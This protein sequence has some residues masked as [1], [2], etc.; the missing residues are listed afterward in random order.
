MT[1]HINLRLDPETHSRI[2]AVAER[3]HRSLNG[4]IEQA[5][6][7]HLQRAD[8]CGKFVHHKDGDPRNLELDS[9]E[10]RDAPRE[11]GR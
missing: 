4:E 5:I 1:K 2:V 10:V 7:E 8:L 11:S 3:N 6:D 9:L